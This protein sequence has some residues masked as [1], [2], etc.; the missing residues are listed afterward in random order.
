MATPVIS[1][2]VEIRD[3]QCSN[4]RGMEKLRSPWG[5][6]PTYDIKQTK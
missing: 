6:S 4:S 5:I 1:T 2:A 3:S